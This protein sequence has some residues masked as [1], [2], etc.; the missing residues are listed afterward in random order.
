MRPYIMP[1]YHWFAFRAL[2][3][4]AQDEEA[5]RT[6]VVRATNKATAKEALEYVL[7]LED[8]RVKHIYNTAS[9]DDESGAEWQVSMWEK[10]A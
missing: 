8:L 7:G 6:T 5:I 2:T 9:F 1:F 4:N 3:V 10:K